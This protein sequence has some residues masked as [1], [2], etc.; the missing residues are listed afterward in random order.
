[1]SGPI[2]LAALSPDAAHW[3]GLLVTAGVKSGAVLVLALTLAR[4]LRGASAAL[5]HLALSTAL[6]AALALPLLSAVV[7]A[8][9]VRVLPALPN[10][11]WARPAAG[12]APAATPSAEAARPD[13]AA[14][15]TAVGAPG[16]LPDGA[17]AAAGPAGWSLPEALGYL[18]LLGVGVLLVRLG[19]G[20]LRLRSLARGAEPLHDEGW[21]RLAGRVAGQLGLAGPVPLRRCRAEVVPMV[22]GVL[23][24]VVLLPA[25]CRAWTD[26]RREV[27][28][29]HEMAHVRRRDP[30]AHVVAQLCQAVYWFNPLVWMTERRLREERERACDDHV[31]SAGADATEYA[32]HLLQ[33]V[34]SFGTG[35]SASPALAMA[36]RSQF[37][38]RMLAILDPGLRRSRISRATAGWMGTLTLLAVLPLAALTPVARPVEGAA[39]EAPYGLGGP[40]VIPTFPDSAPLQIRAVALQYRIPEELAAAIVRAARDEGLDLGLA[41]LLVRTESGFREDLV[42]PWGAVGLTQTLPSTAAA[43]EPGITRARLAER[44]TNLRLGFRHLRTLLERYEG[45][46]AL[47][48]TAYH[49]GPRA[50]ERMRDAGIGSAAVGTGGEEGAPAAETRRQAPPR[51]QTDRMVDMIAGDGDRAAFLLASLDGSPGEALFLD[52]IRASARIGAGGDRRRVLLA[53][54]SRRVP[55]EAALAAAVD[56]TAGMADGD[57]AAVLLA[58][59]GRHGLPGGAAAEE[60]LLGHVLDGAAQIGSDGDR[61]GVLIAV[62]K[63]GPLSASLEGRYR[64]VAGTLRSEGSRRAALSAL[65]GDGAARIG[66]GAPPPP[67]P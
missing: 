17:N 36:R 42:T 10:G 6:A 33:I 31:L 37:E 43:L 54:L 25:G 59:V 57:R 20:C 15:R 63:T 49:T 16:A 8:W 53:V 38:G 30:L 24:P 47:A 2:E 62:A 41:V 52:V 60:R 19:A 67:A 50:V 1:M 14:P 32:S 45:D 65:A 4:L 28:L 51:T 26:D 5:R 56:A 44:D 21:A 3:G 48:L 18:W 46:A 22:W 12:T 29:L 35:T 64:A 34:R 23:R 11:P 39:T 40:L 66:R 55:G 13:G 61:V 27:V 58:A 9:Q 7:P